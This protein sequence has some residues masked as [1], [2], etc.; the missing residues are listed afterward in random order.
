VQVYV[1]DDVSSVPRPVL[2]LKRFQRVSLKPGESRTLRFDLD[3]AALAFWDA[4]M[5]W[6]VEPGTF[7]VSVGASSASLKSAPLRVV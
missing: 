6:V 4:D 2:E 7:T 3:P 1:R 5:K